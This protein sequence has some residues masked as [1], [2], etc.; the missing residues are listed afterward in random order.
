MKNRRNLAGNGKSK[1]KTAPEGLKAPCKGVATQQ[2][3]SPIANR[4]KILAMSG[5][6][7]LGQRISKANR[8]RQNYNPTV[9]LT[10]SRARWLIESY[11]RGEYAELMWTFGAPFTGIENADPDLLALIERRGAA[12]SDFTWHARIVDKSKRRSDFE[13][14]LAEEQQAALYEAY[15]HIDNLQEAIGHLALASFRG[16]SHLEKH[17]H[18]DGDIFHLEV[19]DQWNVV[20]DG[21]WG[22]WKYNPDA[23]QIGFQQLGPEL[24]LD[25][26]EWVIREIHRPINRIALVKYIR[27]NLSDK[28]WDAFIEIYGVPGGVV[29]GPQNVPSD[30]EAEF[31]ASAEQISEGGSGYLPYG[32]DYKPNDGPRGINPFR[33]RLDYLSEK[34]ILAGTGGLLTM[35]TAPTGLGK[36]P[37]DAHEKAFQQI[38]KKEAMEISELFQR[39]ID[40]EILARDFPGKPRLVYFEIAANE[41]TDPGDAVSQIVSLAGAGYRTDPAQVNELTGYKVTLDPA[42]DVTRQ[43]A[44]SNRGKRQVKERIAKDSAPLADR[45]KALLN[46][47]GAEFTAAAKAL[48]GDLP[49]LMAEINADPHA[50]ELLSEIFG[51]AFVEG[52]SSL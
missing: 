8:Y 34:L 40:T 24:E 51:E 16:F 31:Q 30:K 13:P 39:A 21:W 14:S 25:P 10:L 18:P 17:R 7:S 27:Q 5:G 20:R 50:A 15:D 43:P 11:A 4:N 12:L 48:R 22:A 6:A 26:R 49:S 33:D 2:S 1:G 32:S 42:K 45:L 52:I 37:T 41:E 44:L 36:G 35:L 38:A 29:I 46:L 9:G 19:L 47:S 23:L 3:G 28:D